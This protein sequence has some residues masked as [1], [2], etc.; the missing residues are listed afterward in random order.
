MRLNA[1]CGNLLWQSNLTLQA[2]EI[3]MRGKRRAPTASRPE[4][5][6]RTRARSRARRDFDRHGKGRA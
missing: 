6:S 5:D 4:A 3:F 2:Q 1:Y